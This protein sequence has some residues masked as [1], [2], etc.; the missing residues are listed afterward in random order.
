VREAGAEFINVDDFDPADLRAGA[1]ARAT[2]ASADATRV[3]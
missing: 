1:A 2:P 3:A